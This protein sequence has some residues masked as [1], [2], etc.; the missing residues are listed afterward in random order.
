MAD[1]TG[2]LLVRAGFITMKQ[3]HAAH[4]AIRASGQG[5]TLLEH[6]VSTSVLDEQALCHFYRDRLLVPKVDL[7]ELARI[8]PRIIET[9]P[10]DM[11]KEFRVVPVDMDEERN[12]F[13][14]MADPADTHAVD[15]I[16]FFT[17]TTV[18][19]GVAVMSE[20]AWALAYYYGVETALLKPGVVLARNA[21]EQLPAGDGSG[22]DTEKITWGVAVRLGPDGK[23]LRRPPTPTPVEEFA[24]EPTPLP[25][26]VPLGAVTTGPV[27]LLTPS[28]LGIDSAAREIAKVANHGL[29]SSPETEDALESATR[30][31]VTST[32]RDDVAEALV[33]YLGLLCRRS[34]FFIVKKGALAGWAGQGVGVKEEELREARLSLEPPSTFRDIIRTR[35]PYRGPVSDPLARDFLI[36]ALGWAPDDML[37]IPIAVHDRVVGLLYGDDRT[38]PLPDDHLAQ[39]VRAAQDALERILVMM[40]AQEAEGRAGKNE[41]TF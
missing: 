5:E 11:A 8:P 31:L 20:L 23:P 1:N 3:L 15:E 40:K 2:P 4:Q 41:G 34:A 30:T 9:V 36:D 24:D 37:A 38:K 7:V 39:V 10:A 6:L 32:S 22:D 21:E 17:A 35:L 28:E 27:P 29:L 33:T 14:A 12:L 13:L 26:P 19:R 18:V 16:G 25:G